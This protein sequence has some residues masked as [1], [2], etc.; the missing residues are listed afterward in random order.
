MRVRTHSG[1]LRRPV[2]NEH[3]TQMNGSSARLHD[4]GGAARAGTQKRSARST[5]CIVSLGSRVTTGFRVSQALRE[6]DPKAQRALISAAVFSLGV[7][8]RQLR[9]ESL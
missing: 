8:L 4:Y 1:R 7:P 6:S 2:A 3:P 5:C 9:L